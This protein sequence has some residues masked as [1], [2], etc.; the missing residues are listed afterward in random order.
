[1]GIYIRNP[2]ALLKYKYSSTDKSLTSKY[3][4]NP[5]WSWLVTLFPETMAPNAITLLLTLLPP[6]CEQGL[7][8]VFANFLSLVYFNPTLSCGAKP[9]HISLGGS[10]DP[11]L[12]PAKLTE[13]HHFRGWASWL[14][15][16]GSVADKVDQFPGNCAPRWLYWT[17]A[18]GL[19]MYQSL[20]AIDGKQAR[21]TGTSGPLGELF[22][23]GC[24]AINTTL[25][26]IL[27]AS[28]LNLG[29][30]WWTVAALVATSANFYLTT[31]EEFHTG[32]LFLSAFSGPVEGIL[33]VV[34]LFIA[35]GFVGPSYWDQGILTV[36]GLKSSAII[37]AIPFKVKDLPMNDCFIVF[38]LVGLIFNIASA[39][40]NVY[41]S[42]PKKGRTP[43]SMFRPLSRLSPYIIHTSVM[44][45]WLTGRKAD[46]LHSTLLI[47]FMFLWGISFA[48]HVQLLILSHLTAS[49]FP[50]TWKHPLIFIALVGAV[51]ANASWLT[52]GRY[53][54]HWQ[55]THE[56]TKWAVLAGLVLAIM[57]Y[58]HFVWEVIGD[59]CAFYD[60]NC[61]TIKKKEK[62]EA[63]ENGKTV[64][65]DKPSPA[66]IAKQKQQK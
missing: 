29:L 26:V 25:G 18:A 10:W 35:T 44:I 14:G 7:G 51:D 23:H 3:V 28:A 65:K 39:A 60:M 32:N 36:T 56:S 16:G 8:L 42:L 61:L 47:P 40:R 48:H 4:L 9:L 34:V 52:N 41:A 57:V 46:I 50:A 11:L 5:Y 24:D 6:S 55:T 12:A 53:A 33:L 15:L 63:V 22:D 2:T 30:D 37:K 45:F 1:M 66:E 21:R 58:A 62:V 49:A 54:T 20:D 38:S 64:I 59:I 17:F 19:F 13:Q 27:T 31:W 43:A